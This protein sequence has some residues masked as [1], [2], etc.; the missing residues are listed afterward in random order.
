MNA[1]GRDILLD[2]VTPL[3]QEIHRQASEIRSKLR[4]QQ[5]EALGKL[6]QSIEI[7]LALTMY[8]SEKL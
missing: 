2:D 1:N 3:R 8:E 7:A 6:S 4:N 5:W